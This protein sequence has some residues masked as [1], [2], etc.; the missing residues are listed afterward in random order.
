MQL[1]LVMGNVSMT[2]IETI[3]GWGGVLVSPT[4]INK[5]GV[6]YEDNLF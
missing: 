3:A 1:V 4:P 6:K 2:K 5:K